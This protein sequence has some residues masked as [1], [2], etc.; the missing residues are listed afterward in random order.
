MKALQKF[1][2]ALWKLY[3][4]FTKALLK[5]YMFTCFEKNMLNFEQHFAYFQNVTE[6]IV[7]K[8]VTS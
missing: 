3:K 4:S 2:K 6:W 7:S 5:S 8:F 1:I